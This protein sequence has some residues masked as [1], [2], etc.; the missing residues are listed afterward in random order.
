[1]YLI[2]EGITIGAGADWRKEKLDDDAL[3]YG[4][5]DK[6]AGESRS[7]TGVYLSTDLQLGDLQVTG[8]VRNDKHDTYDNYRTWSL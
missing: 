5:P 3:S 2:S 1:Q 4:Y 6:L 8:S 7:T